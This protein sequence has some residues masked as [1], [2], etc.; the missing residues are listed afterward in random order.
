MDSVDMQQGE[1]KREPLGDGSLSSQV[2]VDRFAESAVR[3]RAANFCGRLF[4]R[5]A[6]NRHRESSEG[7]A[8]AA[9]FVRL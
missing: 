1:Q 2:G 5:R 4:V 7:R 8:S 3:P 6:N 9:I